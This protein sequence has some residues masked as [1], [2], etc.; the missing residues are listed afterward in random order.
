VKLGY[1]YRVG[2]RERR[3]DLDSGV[4]RKTPASPKPGD[5]IVQY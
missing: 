1:K 5:F 4:N 3:R 2:K